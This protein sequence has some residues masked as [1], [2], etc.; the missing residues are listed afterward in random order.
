MDPNGWHAV[1]CTARPYIIRR[2]NAIRD[3]L[4]AYLKQAQIAHKLEARYK[5]YNPDKNVVEEIERKMPGDIVSESWYDDIPG[6]AYL[7]VTI[8]NIVCATYIKSIKNKFY[9]TDT[10]EQQKY[11][12]IKRTYSRTLVMDAMGGFGMIFKKNLQKLA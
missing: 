2:H 8:G 11:K 9:V 6:E 10:K 1:H 12:N 5:P 7:D 4:S 3:Q